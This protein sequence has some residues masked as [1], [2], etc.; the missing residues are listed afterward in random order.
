MAGGW[1]TFCRVRKAA[2][3]E[4]TR[5]SEAF[6]RRFHHRIACLE[7]GGSSHDTGPEAIQTRLSGTKVDLI[8]SGFNVDAVPRPCGGGATLFKTVDVWDSRFLARLRLGFA[9]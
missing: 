7:A 4:Y 3:T 2:A 8:G 5:R 9:A 1:P 6:A